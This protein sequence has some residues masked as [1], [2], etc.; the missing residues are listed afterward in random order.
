MEDCEDS[1]TQNETLRIIEYVFLALTS[2]FR[3]ITAGKKIDSCE[4]ESLESIGRRMV[5][6]VDGNLLKPLRKRSVMRR[7]ALN[8]PFQIQYNYETGILLT[9]SYVM[10]FLT[11]RE[12]SNVGV[13]DILLDAAFGP[14]FSDTPLEG[15]L[16]YRAIISLR[17]ECV[18][19]N[20]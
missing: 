11:S 17:A 6:L 18:L 13:S 15:F 3:F 1:K 16:I 20:F 8:L 10:I 12:A 7:T 5:S 2:R 9:F 19:W 4:G 14:K